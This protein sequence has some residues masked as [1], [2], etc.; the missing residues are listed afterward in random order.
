LFRSHR[1]W[2]HRLGVSYDCSNSRESKGPANAGSA[3]RGG[4]WPRKG[5]PSPCSRFCSAQM[6]VALALGSPNALRALTPAALLTTEPV[7]SALLP[8]L[9]KPTLTPC[10]PQGGPLVEPLIRFG[11]FATRGMEQ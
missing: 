6:L 7:E 10:S 11:T 2:S 4:A 9:A 8:L 5:T 3:R 1:Y